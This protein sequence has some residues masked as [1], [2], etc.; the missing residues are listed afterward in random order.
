MISARRTALARQVRLRTA[1]LLPA[2]LTTAALGSQVQVSLPREPGFVEL[3]RAVAEEAGVA[4]TAEI[5]AD[6][7]AVTFAPSVAAEDAPDAAQ[8]IAGVFKRRGG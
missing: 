4:V 5:V 1:V 3:A 6:E 7:I 8:Q 2:A